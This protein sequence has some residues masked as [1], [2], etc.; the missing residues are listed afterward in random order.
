MYSEFIKQD[1]FKTVIDRYKEGKAI[2]IPI[3]LDDCPWDIEFTFEDYYF[4]FRELLVFRKDEKSIGDWN[5]TDKAFTQVAYY[6]RGLLTS[7]TGKSALEVPVHKDEKKI[8][9]IKREEQ[10]EIDFFEEKEVNNKAE[11]KGQWEK[12][13]EAKKRVVENNKLS[14]EAEAKEVI[15]KEKRL[16]QK[17]EIQKRIEKEKSLK[18]KARNDKKIEEEVETKRVVQEERRSNEEAKAKMVTEEKRRGEIAEAQRETKREIILGG[19]VAAQKR[20]TKKSGLAKYNYQFKIAKVVEAKQVVQEERRSDEDVKAK[21][22]GK[23]EWRVGRTESQRETEREIRLQEIDAA[24]KRITEKK[25]L[26][27]YNYQFKIPKVVEAKRVVQEERRGYEEV[28]AKTAVANKRRGEL[29]KSLRDTEREK[30]LGE[31]ISA[32]KRVLK[33]NRSSLQNYQVK[34]AEAINQ[35]FREAKAKVAVEEIRFSEIVAMLKRALK[36]NRLVVH[37]Y[38]VKSATAINQFFKEAKKK[39]SAN[40]KTRVRP[41][42]LIAGLVIFGILIYV[43]TGDSEKQSTTVPEVEVAEVD[44][45]A[46]A[47]T[48][49]N[50]E[51]QAGAILKL[52]IGDTYNDGII[53]A[54]DR[55]NKTGK[56]A[57]MDDEGPMTWN[58]AMNIHER[59]GEGWRL[60]TLDELRLVY[61]N[62]GQG[63]DNRGEFADELYWSATPYDDYQARLLRFSDGNAS[64]HY[65]SAGT[66][67]KFRVRAVQDFKR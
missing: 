14:E 48:K 15:R 38:Q 52:S 44:S 26:A 19:K 47:N 45:D 57:Y 49:T 67:R 40:K 34:N 66:F 22:A 33:R 27:G 16:R 54:V 62:I 3:L 64:Y 55:S 6:V 12:E 43:F 37:N 63:A 65:N 29:A 18:E 39:I 9:N 53:F 17:A 32:L 59:L 13:V 58:N 42:F 7:S 25:G 20:V 31:I 61:K 50:S 21:I 10:I 5:P 23:Q 36:R 4:N 51:N 11:R 60:P 35:F 30:R 56:I 41:E 2:L 28:K 46:G 8:L 1:E 24:Q